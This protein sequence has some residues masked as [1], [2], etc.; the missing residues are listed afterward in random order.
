MATVTSLDEGLG[1][2]LWKK[3]KESIIVFSLSESLDF[4]SLKY[5]GV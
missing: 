4:H 5:V 3:S 1:E 2:S